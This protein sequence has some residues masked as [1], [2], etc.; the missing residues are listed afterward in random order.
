AA[1]SIFAAITT[2]QLQRIAPEIGHGGFVRPGFLVDRAPFSLKGL[3]WAPRCTVNGEPRIAD[4]HIVSGNPFDLTE[5]VL[6][7]PPPDPEPKPASEGSADAH[8]S[9]A[10]KRWCDDHP[11]DFAMFRRECPACGH[12]GCF[13]PLP[14]TP[15]RWF[16]FSANHHWD[17]GGC[18]VP[19]QT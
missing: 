19:S 14:E 3:F 17:S 6:E 1:A 15:D 2:A 5:L 13:G 8:Y 11:I 18:G 9:E 4:V 16:C 10:A 12:R 7:A